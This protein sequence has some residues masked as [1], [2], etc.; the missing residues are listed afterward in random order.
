M[1]GKKHGHR[2]LPHTADIRIE[3]WGPSRESCL[4]EAVRALVDSFADTSQPS[5]E[6][7]SETAVAANSGD[8][9]LVAVLNEVIYVLDTEDAVP[10]DVEIEWQNTALRLRMSLVPARD[11]DLF[12]AIPKAV[13]L[14]GLS[15]GFDGGT[16][17]CTATV[18]D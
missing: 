11:L 3:A 5:T 4:G 17:S 9:A 10:R 15:F 14:H 7:T 16:W 18:D 2:I 1:T 12:G 13:A 6:W 8:D